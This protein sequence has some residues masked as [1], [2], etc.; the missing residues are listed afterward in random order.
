MVGGVNNAFAGYGERGD[1]S[2]R[3]QVSAGGPCCCK[4]SSCILKVTCMGL[5]NRSIPAV[6]PQRYKVDCLGDRYGIPVDFSAGRDPEKGEEHGIGETDQFR[7]GKCFLEPPSR[8]LVVLAVTVVRIQ[9]EV[10]VRNDHGNKAPFF[11]QLPE[12][13]PFPYRRKA[14]LTRQD[15]CRFSVPCSTE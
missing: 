11:L 13:Y 4:E 1:L 9:K 15:Q 12:R 6:C 8:R 10:R 7:S 5:Y 14:C 3:N 2:I